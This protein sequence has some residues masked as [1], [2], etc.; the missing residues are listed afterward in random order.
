[1][2]DLTR[3]ESVLC[4]VWSGPDLDLHCVGSG[5]DLVW[6]FSVLDLFCVGFG[7]CWIR[8]ALDLFWICSGSVLH[9]VGF[10]LGLLPVVLCRLRADRSTAAHVGVIWQEFVSFY[11]GPSLRPVA[12]T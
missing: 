7:V 10:V 12:W 1:M 5:L 2:L 4:W 3:A 8:S 9:W 11:R 6:I